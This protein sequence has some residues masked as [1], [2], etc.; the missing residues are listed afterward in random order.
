MRSGHP[1]SKPR[2]CQ[3]PTLFPCVSPVAA[4]SEAPSRQLISAPTNQIEFQSLRWDGVRCD[5]HTHTCTHAHP[6]TAVDSGGL[7]RLLILASFFWH[8]AGSELMLYVSRVALPRAQLTCT[9][10][11]I[12]LESLRITMSLRCQD[13]VRAS[14]L[15][16]GI[17]TTSVLV[18]S[19]RSSQ[20]LQAHH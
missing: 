13:T 18:R 16:R 12:L 17:L 3:T 19:L 20:W 9:G 15:C 10:Q 6:T 5:L 2:C 11:K 7:R 8:L 14:E 4:P 1:F